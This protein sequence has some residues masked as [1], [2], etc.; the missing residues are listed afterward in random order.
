[1]GEVGVDGEGAD[2]NAQFAAL[3]HRV[4]GVD[5]EIQD[6][7]FEPI[8][9]DAHVVR[10]R[11][12]GPGDLDVHA[13]DPHQH[14]ADRLEGALGAEHHRFWRLGAPDRLQLLGQQRRPRGR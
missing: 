2:G 10:A 14:L 4:A 13:H 9:V 1:V 11:I 8:G 12:E 3:G 5:G 6:H 7:L